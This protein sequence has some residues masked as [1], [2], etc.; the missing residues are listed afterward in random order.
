MSIVAV[1][2]DP[3][4]AATH[5]DP[6]PLYA[7]LRRDAPLS[8]NSELG[9][10]ALARHDDVLAALEDRAAFASSLVSLSPLDRY[11]GLREA[12]YVAGDSARH[13]VLRRV[14]RGI[15][16][17]R[18]VE[19]MEPDIRRIAETLLDELAGTTVPDLAAGYARRLPVLVTCALLGLPEADEA[20]IAAGVEAVFSRVP[21]R[22]ELPAA[23]PAG[24][25]EL[26]AY[27]R[28]AGRDGASA[29][30]A[31]LAAAHEAGEITDAEVID[32][33]FILVAA[34]VKTT[35]T[36]IGGML[37][38]LAENPD[39]AALVWN[40]RVPVADIVEETLRYDAPAQWVARVA[41][42]QTATPHG[43]I[44]AGARVLLLLGSANR[45]ERRYDDPG[46]FDVERERRRHLAFGSGLHFCSGSG[47]ARLEARVALEALRARA[48]PPVLAGA[49]A[50]IFSPA[51]R[52][53]GALPLRITIAPR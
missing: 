8:L 18:P 2:Y 47:L 21:G 48:A 39:Q 40:D 36:L 11:L 50:R 32:I 23:G 46:R 45:D 30:L 34:G 42:R 43:V 38:A 41:V 52:E 22:V 17:R 44:P 4:D 13:D 29:A 31:T 25:T 3:T 51:E 19:R 53:L 35:S 37:L 33:A 24:Y 26:C 20:T 7:A 6:Y 9:V 12:G 14:L 1:H 15:L 16:G 49:P 10:W 5:A 28:A 27:L